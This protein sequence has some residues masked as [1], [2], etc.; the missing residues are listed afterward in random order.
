MS[1]SFYNFFLRVNSSLHRYATREAE[2]FMVEYRD[3]TRAGFGIR[4]LAPAI[5]NDIPVGVRE[6]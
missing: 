2:N 5:W 4:Y 6:A 1:S 3:T